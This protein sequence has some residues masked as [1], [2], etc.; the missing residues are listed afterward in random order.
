MNKIKVKL[1]L[2]FLAFTMLFVITIILSAS[3]GTKTWNGS[4]STDWV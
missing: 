3:A 4:V 1:N 2:E